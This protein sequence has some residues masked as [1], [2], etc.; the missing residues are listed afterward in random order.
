MDQTEVNYNNGHEV[1]DGIRPELIFDPSEYYRSTITAI[2]DKDGVL[3]TSGLTRMK[4]FL[5]AMEILYDV[6]TVSRT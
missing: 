4:I 2:P 6:S 3:K 1:D 5:Y